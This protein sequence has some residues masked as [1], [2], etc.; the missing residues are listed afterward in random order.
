MVRKRRK[1]I[2][3]VIHSLIIS[4]TKSDEK[5][6][7]V[8]IVSRNKFKYQFSLKY[9]KEISGWF[10]IYSFNKKAW[11]DGQKKQTLIIL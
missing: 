5:K 9:T 3:K 2:T 7:V 4:I 11:K 1:T 8:H 10:G 6:I